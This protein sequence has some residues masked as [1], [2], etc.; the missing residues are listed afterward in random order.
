MGQGTLPP[1]LPDLP[2]RDRRGRRLQRLQPRSPPARP[3]RSGLPEGPRPTPS[4]TDAVRRGGAGVGLSAPDAPL[5][6]HALTGGDRSGH[7]VRPHPSEALGFIRVSFGSGRLA[8]TLSQFETLGVTAIGNG[9]NAQSSASPLR[10][11]LFRSA[12]KRPW[13]RDLE[14]LRRT[15]MSGPLTRA[16]RTARISQAWKYA[17]LGAS[18]GVGAPA[19]ALLFRVLGGSGALADLDQT[20]SSIST[21]S[22]APASC[23]LS[24][25]FSRGRRATDSGAGGIAIEAV[26]MDPVRT[27][28]RPSLPEPLLVS[29]SARRS[30]RGAALAPAHRCGWA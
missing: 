6:A 13:Q 27:R 9:P 30:F 14:S 15:T 8:W 22:S 16:D 7:P 24:S 21:I 3:F 11:E 19:G 23:F 17:A 18:L 20:P 29:A 26:G 10:R 25:G 2:R 5:G 12:K 1:L 28:Q 4:L